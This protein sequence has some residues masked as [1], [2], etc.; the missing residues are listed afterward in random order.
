MYIQFTVY[1]LL[2]QALQ[3]IWIMVNGLQ[4]IVILPLIPVQYSA[5]AKIFLG[6]LI[7]IANFDI[8]PTDLFYP[9]IFEF[10]ETEPF[11]YEFEQLGFESIYLAEAMG[12]IFVL[13][14]LFVVCYVFVILF[15]FLRNT[16]SCAFRFSLWLNRKFLWNLLIIFIMEAYIEIGLLSMAVIKRWDYDPDSSI[17]D[18]MNHYYAVGYLIIIMIY[19]FWV[20]FIY[21]YNRKKLDRKEF[22]LRFGGPF[23]GLKKLRGFS[24]FFFFG[25]Y[26]L[27]R[28]IIILLLTLNEG[29]I[30][31]TWASYFYTTI[32]QLCFL[33]HT[34]PFYEPSRN[35]TE[36]FNEIVI[37]VLV[38]PT[39][40]FTE[41]MDPGPQEKVGY[42]IIGMVVL[43]LLVH[44]YI[45]SSDSLGK[46]YDLI[47]L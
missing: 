23:N 9:Y 22:K 5:N 33:L 14:H 29:E 28:F 27:R 37:M 18:R 36:V 11:N 41:V 26:I 38:V 16:C 15:Y 17:N 40:C 30:Y 24:S 39:L 4:F 42:Y 46:L 6:N 43:Y 2:N 7:N 21:V 20:T 31:F 35:R 47:W 19:P 8:I 10:E 44:L 25:F 3:K 12:T 32:A 13:T 45:L 34:K 1:A